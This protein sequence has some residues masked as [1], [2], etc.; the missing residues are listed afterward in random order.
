MSLSSDMMSQVFSLP[1]GERY[2]LAQRLLDSID[3]SA[4]GQ[5]DH[6]FVAELAR[7]REEMIRGEQIVP[8]WRAA[9]SDIDASLL[10]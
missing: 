3:A 6:D 1:V 4:A 9:L 5:I 7:R 8:D 10:T 2:E